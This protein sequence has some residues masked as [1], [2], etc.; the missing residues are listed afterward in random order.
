MVGKKFVGAIP[1]LNWMGG[2]AAV[3]KVSR[4]D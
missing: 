3:W 4:P 1:A 2:F